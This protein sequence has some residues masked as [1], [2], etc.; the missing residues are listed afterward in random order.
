MGQLVI[1]AQP[2]HTVILTKYTNGLQLSNATIVLKTT[3]SIDI[4]FDTNPKIFTIKYYIQRILS[5]KHFLN[6][7][8]LV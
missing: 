7:F 3:Q 5:L 2:F 1:A 6:K 8:R 4:S